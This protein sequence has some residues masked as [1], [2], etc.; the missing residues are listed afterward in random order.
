MKSSLVE[1]LNVKCCIASILFALPV[2]ST[3]LVGTLL[4]TE[5]QAAVISNISVV[6]NQLIPSETIRDFAGI[7]FGEN[8]EPAEINAVVRRL[9]DSGMFENVD[10]RVSG[11]TLV[12][13]VVENPSVSIVAFEGNKAFRD[14]ELAGLV[15]SNSRRPFNRLT[16]EADAQRI[17]LF[18]A[19]SGRVGASVRPVIIPVSEGRVNVVFEVTESPVAG[20]DQVSFVGNSAF[21]DR[22]LRGIVETN[23]SNFLSRIIGRNPIDPGKVARDRQNLEEYYT[24]NGY[25][26]FEILSAVPELVADQS[27]YQLTFSLS[28]GFK[29]DFGQ[30]SVTSS[31]NGVDGAAFERFADIRTGRVF[32]AKDVRDVIDAIEVEAVRQGLPFLRVTPRFTKDEAGRV[33]DVDF[34][35]VNGRR[36]Y[37]ER[38]DISG[39]TST[40][41]RVI[42]RQFD[43]VEG[44]A[45]NPRK[46]AEAADKLRALG[47]FGV[48]N[49]T[50]REGTTPGRA[51]VDV[52]VQ[53][54]ATGSLG[55][56]VGYSS[57]NGVNGSINFSERNFLGRGQEFD[58]EISISEKQ[59]SVSFEFIEPALFGRDVSAGI[60][61]YYR[62]V[63]RSESSFKTRNIG[64][65]PS[66]AFALGENTRLKLGY[67]LSMDEMYDFQDGTAAY[68]A[69]DEGEFITSALSAT[70]SYNRL[71]SRIEPTSGYFLSV[72]EE[73]AGLGGDVSY[74]KTIAR[75]K[76]YTSLFDE[77]MVLSAEVEGGALISEDG[78]SRVTDRFFLGGRTLR[79]FETGGIGPRQDDDSLGGNFYSV[80]RLKSSFPLGLP[81]NLGIYG[82]AFVEGGSVWGLDEPGGIDDEQHWRASAG[83]SLFWATPIGPLEFSY[84]VP[85]E[86]QENDEEENFSISIATRF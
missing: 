10:L 67:R 1:K 15:T 19:Q 4:A 55:F 56:G 6:G 51:I 33:V 64:V 8:L 78:R 14:A 82:G 69:A 25:I 81:E 75:A 50:L 41:E 31:I 7:N 80:V 5:I 18:Y 62:D 49:V 36:V 83:V 16:A 60:S 11:S 40:R 23:E 54:I 68:I 85:F 59:N 53:D 42:R 9:Y 29:Y 3:A 48:T 32:R 30:A 38:I 20:I 66:V 63:D 34:E 86:S 70:L 2:T 43:F 73:F 61:V 44:D 52:E 46:M 79:G 21:S 24:N 76:A 12:I 35:L 74:S 28:E 72:T 71:N 77:A 27:A 84:A 57:D 37:V 39:N 47:I 65:E 17:S 13:T 26:D 58:F 45:F 22:R